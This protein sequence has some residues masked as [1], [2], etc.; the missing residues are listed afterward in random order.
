MHFQVFQLRDSLKQSI[1][2]LRSSWALKYASKAHFRQAFVT[3][4]IGKLQ[5]ACLVDASPRINGLRLI[6]AYCCTKRT[7][8]HW[9]NESIQCSGAPSRC[10]VTA[11]SCFVAPGLPGQESERV[12]SEVPGGSNAIGGR[13][14]GQKYGDRGCI[15]MPEMR[16]LRQ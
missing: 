1:A 15:K 5:R 7:I 8:F 9:G 3:C 6:C 11:E 14:M 2:S 4:R 16:M 13:L 10:S 12:L